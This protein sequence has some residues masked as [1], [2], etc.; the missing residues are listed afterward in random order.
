M[1]DFNQ[2]AGEYNR[3]NTFYTTSDLQ[4]F[5]SDT[6][7]RYYTLDEGDTKDMVLANVT[8]VKD[9]NGQPLTPMVVLRLKDGLESED[10]P[11]FHKVSDKDLGPFK[12][13]ASTKQLLS[14]V[15]DF[16]VNFTID[17]TSPFY[18]S[19]AKQ[20]PLK[21]FRWTVVQ[22]FS[23]ENP[24]LVTV[25]LSITEKVMGAKGLDQGVMPALYLFSLLLLGMSSLFLN[26]MHYFKMSKLFSTIS[27]K[28]KQEHQQQLAADLAEVGVQSKGRL[29]EITQQNQDYVHSLQHMKPSAK[30][31][32]DD[33]FKEK[34]SQVSGH[35]YLAAKQRKSEQQ[36]FAL[37]QAFNPEMSAKHQKYH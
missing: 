17:G 18:V 22:T 21:Y 12:D 36:L 4:G 34:M 15:Q 7:N 19:G 30:V 27:Y 6:V 5:I 28:Y 20:N 8:Q 1:G 10:I 29:T 13:N 3:D 33:E 11:M 23:V 14:Q 25:K 2:L 35:T 31:Y 24:A 26:S 37:A 9:D 16:Y 32:S